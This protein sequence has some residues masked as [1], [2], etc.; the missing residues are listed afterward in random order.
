MGLGLGGWGVEGSGSPGRL[1]SAFM[2]SAVVGSGLLHMNGTQAP[3]RTPNV[4]HSKQH[5]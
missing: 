3:V 5:R 2:G 4:H 1:D